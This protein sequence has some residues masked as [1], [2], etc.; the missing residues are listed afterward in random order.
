MNI[1]ITKEAKDQLERF[2]AVVQKNK[3]SILEDFI[4]AASVEEAIKY[5][6]LKMQIA[7]SKYEKTPEEQLRIIAIELSYPGKIEE[8]REIVKIEQ[9]K[10]KEQEHLDEIEDA[11]KI[12][13]TK[14][15]IQ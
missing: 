12:A 3:S 11:M 8:N 7:R 14:W 13:K 1:S 5:R 15:G 6:E 10:A 9:E 4:W 2:A